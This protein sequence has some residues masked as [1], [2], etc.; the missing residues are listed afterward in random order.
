MH[1]GSLWAVACNRLFDVFDFLP[2]DSWCYKFSGPFRHEKHNKGSHD[3]ICQ[4]EN[5]DVGVSRKW[6][7]VDPDYGISNWH[8]YK[9]KYK[10]KP[11]PSQKY[12]APIFPYFPDFTHIS[13][14]HR[15]SGVNRDPRTVPNRCVASEAV[16]I[17]DQLWVVG[18]NPL[19][20]FL[21]V[22]RPVRFIG[23]KI[24][25]KIAKTWP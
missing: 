21:A 4:Y 18:C 17:A 9:R 2:T 6:G 15:T 25:R 8:R 20:E 7:E 5:G 14:F 1:S 23:L 12:P 16:C 24:V 11:Q 13:F 19:L 10:T 3:D 22:F